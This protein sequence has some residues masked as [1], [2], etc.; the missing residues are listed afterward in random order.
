MEKLVQNS[1]QFGNA[2]SDSF[3]EERTSCDLNRRSRIISDLAT[4]YNHCTSD[5]Y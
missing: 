1:F 3:V 4:Q 5:S 2:G